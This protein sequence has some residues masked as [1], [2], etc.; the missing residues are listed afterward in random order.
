MSSL[1]ELTGEYLE[2]MEMSMTDD[3]EFEQVIRDTL[4]GLEGEIEI[5]VENYCKLMKNLEGDVL[6]LESEINRL[7]KKK[8][9]IENNIER[10][11]KTLFEM[12]QITNKTQIKTDL[13]TLKIAGIGGLRKLTLDVDVEELPKEFR[14]KQPDKV[15]GT[16]LREY[17]EINGVDGACDFAHLE[18]QGKTLRIR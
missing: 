18:P 10:M 15:D 4:E 12:M 9:T 16:A 17:I 5:K 3:P 2:L 6:V 13:F 7:S 8:K 14:I 11:K 1:Y